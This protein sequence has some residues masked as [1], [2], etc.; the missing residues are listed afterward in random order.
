MASSGGFLPSLI[1]AYRVG[2]KLTNAI[3]GNW[4]AWKD[5]VPKN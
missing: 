2:A 5:G 1:N 4:E 3:T